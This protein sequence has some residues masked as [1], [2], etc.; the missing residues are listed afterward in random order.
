MIEFY[1]KYFYK[2]YSSKVNQLIHDLK[3]LLDLEKIKIKNEIKIIL[4]SNFKKNLHEEQWITLNKLY[5]ALYNNEKEL[6][7]TLKKFINKTN[8]NDK[9]KLKFIDTFAGCGGLSLGLKNAGFHPVYVNEIE[10]KYLETYYFN[11]DLKLDNYYCG[12]IKNLVTNKQLTTKYKNIDLIVGGPPC[13]GFSMAN[14]QRLIDDPRNK[15]YKY[16]LELLGTLSPKC[17]LLC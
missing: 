12:D 4:D 10:P 11:H 7:R 3:R 9:S 8:D 15:L 1:S 16:F 13:Q 2:N 14:R 17:F 5:N 6:S